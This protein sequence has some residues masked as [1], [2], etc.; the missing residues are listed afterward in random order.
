MLKKLLRGGI[1]L[2][3]LAAG[4]G[5][6]LLFQ[7][8]TGELGLIAPDV[9][10]D[11]WW[12]VISIAFALIFGLLFFLLTPVMARKSVAFSKGLEAEIKH[13]SAQDLFAGTVGLIIGLVIAFLISRIFLRIDNEALSIALTVAVYI[14]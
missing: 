11:F 9:L 1:T 8:V 10:T 3:G 6:F 4:Y 2:V 5:V 13:L 7:Y 12:G 14:V